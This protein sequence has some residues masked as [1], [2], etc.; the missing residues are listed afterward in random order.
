MPQF[1][2]DIF[3]GPVITNM[4]MDSSLG[5]PSPMSNGVGPMAR[6]YVFDV[7]PAAVTANS[8]ATAQQLL[9]ASNLTLSSGTGGVTTTVDP[10]GVTRYVLDT[11]RAV[12]LASVGDLSLIT[13]TVTGYDL[14]G[15]RMTQ[16]LAGPNNNTVNTLKAFKSVI[17]IAASAAVATD[18]T[19]GTSSILG[20]PVR[21]TVAPYIIS[22]KWNL[23]LADDAGAFVPAVTT[24]P[25]TAILGDVRGTYLPTTPANGTRR[26]IMAIAMPAIA[27][28]PNA[29]RVGALGV[30]QA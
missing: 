8:L 15:Q 18:V 5:D 19:A 30:T 28:G 2:D 17:S 7:V 11:P 4:G 25:S 14:Y 26:L 16:A 20:L 6:I 21:V 22:A 13:F 27:V 1:S 9:A 12:S 24:D 23:A 10:T 3:L 29:T